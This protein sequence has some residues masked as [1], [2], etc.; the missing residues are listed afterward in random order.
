MSS[1]ICSALQLQETLPREL[2]RVAVTRRRSKPT[3]P[4]RRVAA[5]GKRPRGRGERREERWKRSAWAALLRSAAAD[6]SAER[7]SLPDLSVAAVLAWADAHHARTGEWPTPK[8]GPI[9]ESPAETWLT[10]EAALWLGARG[11]PRGSTLARFLGEHR[12]RYNRKEP[13]FSIE[14]ILAWMDAWYA[15]T[16]KWPDQRSGPVP[17]AEGVSWAV[18]DDALKKGRGGLPAGSSLAWLRARERGVPHSRGLSRLTDDQIV[19]WADAFHK[20]TGR[21]PTRR[22]GPIKDAPGETWSAVNIALFLGHRGLPGGSSLARL[23]SREREVRK[24]NYLPPLRVSQVLRWSRAH[25]DR[26]GTWPKRYSGTVADAPQETWEGIDAALRHGLRGLPAGS[27]VARLLAQ[28]LGVRNKASL[29]PLSETQVLRWAKAHRTRSGQWPNGSSGPIP[30]APGETWKGVESALRQGGRGLP[31][32]SS[33]PKLLGEKRR[34]RSRSQPARL[35]IPR[36]LAWADAFHTR[37]GR[38]PNVA[39]GP[40]AVAPGENWRT[41]HE[42]LYKG[43]R[44]LPGGCSLAQLLVQERG[45]RSPGHL[46]PLSI[47]QVL[48]WARAY[49]LRHGRWPTTSSGPIPEAPGE[50]W[51][52][53]DTA[54]RQGWRGLRR[55]TSLARLLKDVRPPRQLDRPCPLG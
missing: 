37:T 32:G 45:V 41:V 22:S 39:S 47:P 42:A 6:A 49:R 15:R 40:I 53:V 52:N 14:Q 34:S 20:S 1:S 21:W 4:S 54:L 5:G 23:M 26:F 43:Y 55:R 36:I 24:R 46:P 33:L 50:I 8:S 35:T 17:G 44:G 31:G 12:G 7:G 27:S 38:W 18:L 11:F 25:F 13:H 28:R 16:G 29:R 2:H 10:I 30:D 51:A 19:R 48:H 3:A 9:P